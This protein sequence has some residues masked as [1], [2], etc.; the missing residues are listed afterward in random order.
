MIKGDVDRDVYQHSRSYESINSKDVDLF[1]LFADMI[2]KVYISSNEGSGWKCNRAI[3]ILLYA[4]KYTPLQGSSYVKYPK[5]IEDYVYNVKNEDEECFKWAILS[6][7][8]GTNKLSKLKVNED[9]Y[10]F[11]YPMKINDIEKFE[12]QYNKCI[13]VYSYDG[14]VFYPIY[15]SKNIIEDIDDIIQ[16]LF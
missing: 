8:M 2:M 9:K 5:H 12:K 7:E 4:H 13:V 3:S 15:K 10:K 14:N 11:N 6:K 16:L 1:E